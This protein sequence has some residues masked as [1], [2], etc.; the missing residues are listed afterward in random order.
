MLQQELTEIGSYFSIIKMIAE[1]KHK[2]SEIAAALKIKATSLTKYLKTLID[3]VILEREVPI[4]ENYPEK[5]RR[6]LYKITDHYI[7]FWFSFVYPNMGFLEQGN[8]KFVMDKIRRSFLKNH[9]AFIYE[10]V[11]REKMWELNMESSPNLCV[12]C[13]R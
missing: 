1:G 6:G 12:K 13:T 5:S 10:D 2:L 4:T 7:H 9:V 3:L 8:E 11:C